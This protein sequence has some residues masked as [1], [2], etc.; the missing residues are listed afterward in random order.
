MGWDG[1]GVLAGRYRRL[2]RIGRGGMG[3]VWRAHDIDLDRTVAV[4]EL[5]VP[6][7]VTDQER[8][9]WYARMEREARAA[10]RLRHPGIVTVFD[11][12][13]GE[14][15]RP[16][17]VMELVE[18]RS[19][20]DVLG[21]QG[22]LPPRRV[23]MIG[24]AMLD[25]LSAAHAQGVVHRDVKPANVLL[26]GDRVL[27]TDFGIAALEG[28]ATI[29]RS[30][31]VL[32]T[33]AFMSPEQVEGKPVT[34]ASDLWSLAATLYAAVEG[35]RPFDGPSHGAVFI[36]IATRRP[37]APRCGGPLAQAIDGL[38]RKDP[39][40][41]LQPAQVRDLFNAA[42]VPTADPAPGTVADETVTD[43]GRRVPHWPF[44]TALLRASPGDVPLRRGRLLLVRAALVCTALSMLTYLVGPWPGPGNTRTLTFYSPETL[45]ILPLPWIAAFILICVM[46][47]LP[48]RPAFVLGLIFTI[49]SGL[50]LE[51]LVVY[52]YQNNRTAGVID[53][54]DAFQL[55]WILGTLALLL[56]STAVNPSLAGRV[57]AP[58]ARHALIIVAVLVEGIVALLWPAPVYELAGSGLDILSTDGSYLDDS[59]FR[60]FM[61]LGVLWIGAQPLIW[62]RRVG[63]FGG[64]AGAPP[65]SR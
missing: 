59:L 32:G 33:P 26:E 58:A 20:G 40:E 46:W 41:R 3:S 10:A 34:P 57:T 49:L 25:A 64:I 14:D 16:W 15:G 22:A 17:I 31:M 55:S 9:D 43:I 39:D 1:D 38:L 29:T 48:H 44:R 50:H 65:N 60:A 7:Q 8:R 24:L 47:F 61:F 35:R 19:L 56:A 11:R 63:G 2:G 18:G 6:E 42:L 21:E 13:T 52:S 36:A 54:N 53:P 28:D 27:L 5:L 51:A 12:V 30:G 37:P 62:S 23:A 4:K 45:I